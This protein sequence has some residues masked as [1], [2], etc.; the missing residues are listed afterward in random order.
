MQQTEIQIKTTG[1]DHVVLW[2]NDLERSKAF[3]ID[4]LGM[5]VNHEGG[6][7]CFLWCGN[8]QVALAE[9]HDGALSRRAPRAVVRGVL[10]RVDLRA[11][12]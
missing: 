4:L 12:S 8:D 10:A 7:N 5:T 3:Y 2:V 11:P 9:A 6:G 1:I